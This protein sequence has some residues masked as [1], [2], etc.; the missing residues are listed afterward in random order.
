M[1]AF[2]VISF[3]QSIINLMRRNLGGLRIV[4]SFCCFYYCN[5]LFAQ[6]SP[7]AIVR[8]KSFYKTRSQGMQ[9]VDENGQPVPLQPDV[10]HFTVLEVKGKQAPVVDSLF[11]YGRYCHSTVSGISSRNW[12][13]GTLKATGQK[14][15]WKLQPGTTIWLVEYKVDAE[16]K[17]GTKA[18]M[19]KGKYNR[20]KFRITVNREDELEPDIVQ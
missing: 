3:L 13:I 6:T 18:V 17:P 15:S 9:M 7:A 8:A 12:I 10:F 14:A 16:Q 1:G 20:Q 11:Y 4:V 5:L 19:I 2:L